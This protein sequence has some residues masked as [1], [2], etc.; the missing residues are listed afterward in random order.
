MLILLVVADADL[1]AGRAE[2]RP[3]NVEPARARE[4][5]VGVLALLQEVDEALEL[6]WVERP[7]IR[8]LADKV[9]RVS[10][11]AHLAVH[12]LTTE[13]RSDDDRPHD[14]PCGLQQQMTAIGQIGY[15]LHCW[16]VLRVPAQI[17]ELAQEKVRR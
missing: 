15:G 14:E 9:L 5:L 7:D 6:L 3:G 10:H 8:G 11:A 13:A 4:Q 17:E 1:A 16:N 12:S 2:G